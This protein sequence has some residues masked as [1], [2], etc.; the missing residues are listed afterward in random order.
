LLEKD[1]LAGGRGMAP[2]QEAKVKQKVVNSV[3][4]T[5]IWSYLKKRT[6]REPSRPSLKMGG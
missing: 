2:L 1:P 4:K 3:E 6:L 5:T